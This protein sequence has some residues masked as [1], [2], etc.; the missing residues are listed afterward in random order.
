MKRVF[1]LL[2]LGLAML[3]GCGS[4]SSEVDSALA[5]ISDGCQRDC[6]TSCNGLRGAERATCMKQCLGGQCDN[7][8]VPNS[9]DGLDCSDDGVCNEFCAVGEDPDCDCRDW[10][11]EQATD[12]YDVCI[13]EVGSEFE[14]AELAREFYATCV[15]DCEP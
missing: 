12:V 8:G 1:L 7:P 5:S 4:E 14:C 6:V 2:G 15:A 3:A 10:C 13:A 11:A 9:G